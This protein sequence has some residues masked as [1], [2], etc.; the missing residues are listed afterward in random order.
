MSTNRTFVVWLFVLGG[1]LPVLLTLFTL[2]WVD[3]RVLR[4]DASPEEAVQSAEPEPA[5][6]TGLLS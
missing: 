2:R 6:A 1:V 5:P 3:L 4:T